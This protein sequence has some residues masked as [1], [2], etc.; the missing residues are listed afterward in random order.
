MSMNRKNCG[1][2]YGDTGGMRQLSRYIDTKGF[3]EIDVQDESLK[4]RSFEISRTKQV[5]IK[6]TDDIIEQ[7]AR[8]E[9][10]YQIITATS[11]QKVRNEYNNHTP[12]VKTIA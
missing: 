12:T 2:A 3:R 10:Y 8:S 6:E 5:N 7:C 11:Q 1:V 9:G 4:I